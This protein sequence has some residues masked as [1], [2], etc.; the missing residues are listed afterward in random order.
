MNLL[1]L[2]LAVAT[3]LTVGAVFGFL[4]LSIGMRTEGD[5]MNSDSASRDPIS[6]ATRRILGVYVRRADETAPHDG[7]K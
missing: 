2:I 4:M 1:S 3:A 5:R 7:R 6:N